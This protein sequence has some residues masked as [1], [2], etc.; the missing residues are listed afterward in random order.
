MGLLPYDLG[1]TEVGGTGLGTLVKSYKRPRVQRSPEM[2]RGAPRRGCAP[3][4]H[5]PRAGEGRR[6]TGVAGIGA[7]AL[8]QL[9]VL[10]HI[11][12]PFPRDSSAVWAYL[13]A[14]VCCDGD[15]LGR[16]CSF[17]LCLHPQGCLRRG[18]RASCS[19]QVRTGK[20]GSFSMLHHP[21]GYVSNFLV[22]PASS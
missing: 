9:C 21:L 19:P 16:Q 7:L 15:T 2:D 20:L 18:V 6:K 1:R 17:L 10:S 11:P 22:R 3:A 4:W 12:L 5:D 14:Q 8:C 13:P